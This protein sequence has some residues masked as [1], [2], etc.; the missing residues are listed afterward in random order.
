MTHTENRSGGAYGYRELNVGET[1]NMA[2]GGDR[3][4]VRL[5][6]FDDRS[7]T[8]QVNRTTVR[9]PLGHFAD[10]RLG[11]PPGDVPQ[12]IEIGGLKI[13]AEVT[14]AL[15][16]GTRYS[17]SLVNL[18]KDAR[19]WIGQAGRPMS[20]PGPHVFPLPDY[21]WHF[22]EN[23]LQPV[24]YGWH[25]GVDLDAQR[26]HPMVAVAGGTVVA[27]RHYDPEREEEDYWGNN[28]GLLGDDGLL[29]CYM[30]WDRLATGV[31]VGSRLR[32]GEPVGWVGRSGFETKPFATHLHLE[33]MVLKRPRAFTFAY[34]LEPDVLPTPNRF[35]QPE[36]GGYAVDPYPYLVEWYLA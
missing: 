12:V 24:P 4:A 13:G 1:V 14:R 2:V 36:L 23:W 22:G 32:A 19:L 11:N 5:V 25:L 6:A 30:H 10:R 21:A 27:I 3:R 34:E 26:G 15:M 16:R 29:T 17:R 20:P 28:L 18:D 31:D 9:I 33:V 7:V 8:V 35:L